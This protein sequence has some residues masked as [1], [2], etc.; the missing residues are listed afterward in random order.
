M[1]RPPFEPYWPVVSNGAPLNQFY[2]TA[3]IVTLVTLCFGHKC[4]VQTSFWHAILLP[5]FLFLALAS[6]VSVSVSIIIIIAFLCI[7]VHFCC[8]YETN[9]NDQNTPSPTL[10]HQ[11]YITNIAPVPTLQQNTTRGV[12]GSRSQ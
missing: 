9:W 7:F 5:L 2:N 3:T 1:M 12:H 4:C 8:C 6:F 10:H 11:H